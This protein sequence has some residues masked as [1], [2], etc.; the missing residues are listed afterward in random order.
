MRYKK[1]VA[2]ILLTVKWDVSTGSEHQ[3]K[4]M[5]RLKNSQSGSWPG[6]CVLHNKF[7]H[8]EGPCLTTARLTW[9]IWIS[10]PY[11]AVNTLRLGYTNQSV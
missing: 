6:L 3:A 1:K 11:R 4:V 7:C 2:W 9:I 8:L 5:L 10:S